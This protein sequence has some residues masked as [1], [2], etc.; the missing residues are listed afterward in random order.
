[1]ESIRKIGTE[2]GTVALAFL[3]ISTTF[4]CPSSLALTQDGNIW[5]L[6]PFGFIGLWFGGSFLLFFKFQ[7][8]NFDW[9]FHLVGLAL[10][11]I[12]SAFNDTRNV[13]SNWQES[14]ESHCTWTGITCHDG[15]QRVRSMYVS[16]K[17]IHTLRF[18]S[19]L[20]LSVFS[21]ALILKFVFGSSEICLT[22]N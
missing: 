13:L 16:S 5:K 12:K 2:M 15:E 7:V 19:L 18:F 11:E 1:M 4:F 8:L 10:L 21:C 3:V 20:S 14:D 9:I 6:P 22:C 17:H